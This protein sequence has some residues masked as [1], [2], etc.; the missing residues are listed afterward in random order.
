MKSQ[1]PMSVKIKQAI[2]KMR[3]KVRNKVQLPDK[4]PLTSI[5]SGA[6]P[7]R[8]GGQKR[9]AG[10]SFI[11]ATSRITAGSTNLQ[12]KDWQ[13]SVH[14]TRSSHFNN[15]MQTIQPLKNSSM[16][17]NSKNRFASNEY[18]M[19]EINAS[20]SPQVAKFHP[21]TSLED[22]EITAFDKDVATP[23]LTSNDGGNRLRDS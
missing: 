12:F 21:E 8:K 23:T 7:G 10:R 3:M 2:A 19:K 9:K 11:G 20:S 1:N 6:G 14:S 4:L 18:N 15:Q 16:V 17:D 5:D 13:T 22:T